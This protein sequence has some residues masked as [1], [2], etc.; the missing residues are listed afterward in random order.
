ML[1]SIIGVLL[2]IVIGWF[3]QYLLPWWGI[4]L[5]GILL[6]FLLNLSPLTSFSMGFLGAALLWGGLAGY[7]DS[8][9]NGLLSAKMG[10]LLGNLPG[11]YLVFITAFVGALLGGLGSLI[12]KF[13]RDLVQS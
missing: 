9:N 13:S 4:C 10:Q 8:L 2:I 7:M 3:T 12:G 6:G 1:K 5:V 11:A